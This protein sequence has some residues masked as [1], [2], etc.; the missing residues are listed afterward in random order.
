MNDLFAPKKWQNPV[1]VSGPNTFSI[2]D[3]SQNQAL[4]ITLKRNDLITKL[5]RDAS[6]RFLLIGL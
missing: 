3:L 1:S 6:G 4:Q 5:S 2:G